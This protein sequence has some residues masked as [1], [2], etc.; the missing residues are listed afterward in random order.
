MFHYLI[1]VYQRSNNFSRE[2][3]EFGPFLRLAKS[4][5]VLYANLVLKGFFA[6]DESLSSGSLIARFLLS[7]SFCDV[8]FR[9]KLA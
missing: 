8:S 9:K 1:K 3:N 5:A 6:A 4:Q 7:N 2:S